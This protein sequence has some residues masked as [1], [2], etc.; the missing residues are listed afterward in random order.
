MDYNAFATQGAHLAQ[1]NYSSI[2]N[3]RMKLCVGNLGEC[4]GIFWAVPNIYVCEI[5]F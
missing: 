2:G 3:T 5:I 4:D 1:E